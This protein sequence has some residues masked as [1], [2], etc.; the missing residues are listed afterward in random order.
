MYLEY[1]H[2]SKFHTNPLFA[3]GDE[4][5]NTMDKHVRLQQ[6]SSAEFSRWK[7]YESSRFL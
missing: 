4:P 5:C 6:G 7:Q 3:V 1:T 2:K